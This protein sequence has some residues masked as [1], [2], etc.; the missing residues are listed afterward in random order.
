MWLGKLQSHSKSCSSIN[1][2]ATRSDSTRGTASRSNTR[3]GVVR[4]HSSSTRRVRRLSHEAIALP[5]VHEEPRPPP[6]V[7][8]KIER[9]AHGLGSIFGVVKEAKP[10]IQ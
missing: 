5:T 1:S 7:S 8:K 9:S 3:P 2:V 6:D 10:A 4:R